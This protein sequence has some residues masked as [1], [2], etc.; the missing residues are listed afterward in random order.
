MA[1]LIIA[2]SYGVCFG[3]AM[4]GIYISVKYETPPRGGDL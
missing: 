1:A 3:A 2:F 4:A